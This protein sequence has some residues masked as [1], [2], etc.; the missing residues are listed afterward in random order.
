M[1]KSEN[2]FQGFALF[3]DRN[4]CGKE[5]CLGSKEWVLRFQK[6]RVQFPACI[7]GSSQIPVTPTRIR[8]LLMASMG[9]GTYSGVDIYMDMQM[10]KDEI[11][12]KKEKNVQTTFYRYCK[13]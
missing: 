2:S 12:V 7:R 13:D 10:I 4:L 5:R 9:P 1:L 6:T 11:K 8:H 3:R